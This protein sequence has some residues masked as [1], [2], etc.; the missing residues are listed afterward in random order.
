[1]TAL[2]LVKGGVPVVDV[3]LPLKS[4]HTYNEVLDLDDADELVK[5]IKAFVSDNAIAEVFANV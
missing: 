1:M 2:S 4:M 3:G 5:L